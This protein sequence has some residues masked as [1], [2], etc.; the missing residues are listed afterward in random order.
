MDIW[1][2]FW[3]SLIVFG[4]SVVSGI[5]G[6]IG[7]MILLMSMSAWFPPAV[8]IP[9][10]GMIQSLSNGTRVVLYWRQLDWRQLVWFA[11]GALIGI[12]AGLI[13]LPS[14]PPVVLAVAIGCTALLLTWIP[15]LIPFNTK[16]RSALPGVGLLA[17]GA[18]ST[19]LSLLAGAIG[20]LMD[21]F[22]VNNSTSK[23]SFLGTKAGFQFMNHAGKIVVYGIG[24]FAVQQY[25]PWLLIAFPLA[26]AGNRLGQALMERIP[27][28]PFMM[29]M[30]ILVSVLAV[31]LLV[32]VL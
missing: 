18:G 19:F 24:G 13:G 26:I 22:L 6:M 25:L 17:L 3:F 12:L 1:Q 11:P 23:R 21:A 27:S 10:H 31:G 15:L 14:I 4:S 29:G 7:G 9:L 28:E 2:V 20:P 8:L 32:G 5:A 16:N 30:R